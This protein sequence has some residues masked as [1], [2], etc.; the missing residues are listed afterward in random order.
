MLNRIESMYDKLGKMKVDLED[1]QM[2]A[3][4]WKYTK[5]PIPIQHYPLAS[6]DKPRTTRGELLPDPD[7]PVG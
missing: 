1:A 6:S 2:M 5:P 3:D 7:K 4:F